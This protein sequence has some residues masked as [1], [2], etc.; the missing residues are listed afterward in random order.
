MHG[1]GSNIKRCISSLFNKIHKLSGGFLSMNQNSLRDFASVYIVLRCE[2]EGFTRKHWPSFIRK[3]LITH[4]VL[5]CKA[6]YVKHEFL[7]YLHLL[8]Q[9]AV[10]I[11][12]Q[13]LKKRGAQLPSK[14]TI[15]NYQHIYLRATCFDMQ[16]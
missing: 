1:T 7:T 6:D 4:Y 16:Q 12:S 3:S 10:P 13:I 5:F 8:T 11:V 14:T 2:T 9:I 15:F